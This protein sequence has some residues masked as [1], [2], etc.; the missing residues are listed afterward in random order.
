[1]E[2]KFTVSE[3]LRAS[4]A[5]LKS[6][7]WI[8]A[9]LFVGYTILSSV[10]SLLLTP[11]MTSYTSIVIGDLIFSI[12][13][14][15]FILGYMKNLFQTLDGDEPQF[16][17]Y[18][19]QARKIGTC[20][21]AAV[22]Y[23][24]LVFIGTVLLIIPGVYLSLRLQFFLPL[25]VEEDAGIMDSLKKSWSMTEN[26]V[27]PLF[28]LALAATGIFIIGTILFLVGLF[29]AFPFIILM[30]CY[31]FRKL[32]SPLHAIEEKQDLSDI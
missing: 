11:V 24:F 8:L 3:V 30:Q 15:V 29:V 18:G 19:Q 5:A 20:F 12:I 25:I 22:L 6:Q 1:M 4:W 31:V 2:S 10:F 32:N 7:I 21:V 14:L 17:A 16:S 27:L 9:G 28:L 23:G 26:Q 13:S